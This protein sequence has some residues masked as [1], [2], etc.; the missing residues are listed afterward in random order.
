MHTMGFRCKGVVKA[1]VWADL[2]ACST[3]ATTLCDEVSTPHSPLK[4]VLALI[5]ILPLVP[6]HLPCC[7]HQHQTRMSTSNESRKVLT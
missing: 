3:E 5:V 6:L 7:L 1:G 2:G 4:L